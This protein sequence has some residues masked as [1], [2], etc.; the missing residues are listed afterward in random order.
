MKKKYSFWQIFISFTVV[1]TIP[2]VLIGLVTYTQIQNSFR[3]EISESTGAKLT[4]FGDLI[5]TTVQEIFNSVDVFIYNTDVKGIESLNKNP[6]ITEYENVSTIR[7]VFDSLGVLHKTHDGLVDSIYFY[8]ESTGLVLTSDNVLSDIDTFYD[9]SWLS[10]FQNL[11]GYR[12]WV[13]EHTVTTEYNLTS[14]DVQKN[15]ITVIVRFSPYNSNVPGCIVININADELRTMFDSI[16]NM[17]DTEDIML[18]DTEGIPLMKYF[19]NSDFSDESIQE[20]FAPVLEAD[21]ENNTNYINFDADN[22]VTYKKSASEPWYY[23]S[24]ISVENFNN[25]AEQ[26]F[27]S[28]GITIVALIVFSLILSYVLSKRIF[29][30]IFS[31]TQIVDRNKNNL[32]NNYIL[33]LLSGYLLPD[34]TPELYTVSFPNEKFVIVLAR[35]DGLKDILLRK[36][37]E[38]KLCDDIKRL[39]EKDVM[40]AYRDIVL[41]G[42]V[43]EESDIYFIFNVKNSHKPF[44]EDIASV[45]FQ[46]VKEMISS[47]L[48]TTMSLAISSWYSDTE[49][50]PDALEEVEALIRLRF[51]YGGDSIL[52]SKTQDMVQSGFAFPEKIVSAMT[53][54][55]TCAAEDKIQSDVEALVDFLSQHRLTPQ[56]VKHILWQIVI[57]ITRNLSN[58]HIEISEEELSQINEEINSIDSIRKTKIWIITYLA[59]ITSIVTLSQSSQKS[60]IEKIKKH[61]DENYC[62]IIQVPL[63]AEDIGISYAHLRRIFKEHFHVGV[64]DYIN[65]LRIEKAKELLRTT[66][67]TNIE[68][69]EEVGYNNVQ[70]LNRFFK[71]YMGITPG[72]YKKSF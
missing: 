72:D 44:F 57:D 42:A 30:S 53:Y 36:K 11:S 9:T 3:V 60:V 16:E 54:H 39:A 70:S 68:I 66:N 55:A 46:T 40:Q 1:F 62:T 61:I 18:I 8:I 41:Y 22:V 4:L 47:E 50:L 17:S 35:I 7:E 56:N 71:K 63:L 33:K 25:K 5:D 58:K 15:Y 48:D 45:A 27:I 23:I 52:T 20:I 10:S 21:R 6:I 51:Y 67:K 65:E 64:Y 2:V 12:A 59:N 32:Q 28:I 49:S 26:V 19:G 69:A 37:D 34:E 38:K 43:S 31:V 29:T 24:I 13:S 14:G